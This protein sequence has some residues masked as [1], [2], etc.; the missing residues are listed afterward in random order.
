MI[1]ITVPIH[2]GMVT[3]EG[4]PSVT[5]RRRL[6][7][8]GGDPANVSEVRLGSHTGTHI[9]APAHFLD[10]APTLDGVP[11][12]ALVGPAIVAETPAA[13]IGAGDCE[14]LVPVD[15]ERVIFKTRNSV[16]W[17]RPDFAREYVAL[18]LAAARWLVDRGVRLVGIDYLS[19]EA[20]G[21]T[22]HPVHKTLL[23]AGVVVLEGLDLS[24]V[25]PGHYE[26][27]CLPLRLA[28]GD[29][30]PCRALLRPLGDAR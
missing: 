9:D 25:G 30:A 27:I 23:G 8:A 18:D 21:A 6:S 10:G 5:V 2:D 28:G 15:A 24:A 17:R 26:L 3:Y 22:G 14:T 29:G 19:I 20:F 1:D 13:M 7:I 16:L 4:D 11:L 12:A